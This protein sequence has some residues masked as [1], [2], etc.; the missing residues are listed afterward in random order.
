[1]MGFEDYRIEVDAEHRHGVIFIHD[2]P[3]LIK[4]N[5]PALVEYVNH[6]TQLMA[7]KHN[8]PS[9]FFDINNYRRERENLI[10]ELARVAARKVF[11]TRQEISLPAMNSY[12][13]RLVHLELAVH[14]DVTTE[15]VGAGRERYVIVKPLE[16]HAG[17]PPAASGELTEGERVESGKGW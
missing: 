5:L 17:Q 16:N 11:S 4:D 15:S 3:A 10:V 6:L 8:Q 12:E 13:R 7:R 2:N 1:M 14:P 9:V